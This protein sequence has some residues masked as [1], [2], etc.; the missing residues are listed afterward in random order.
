MNS[1]QIKTV[2]LFPIRNGYARKQFLIASLVMLAGM[3]IP[4]IPLFFL[5]GY[6]ARIVRQI[7][8]EKKEPSMTEWDN[9][10]DFFTD[11]ARLFA[12]H[13]V[14]TL[15]FLIVAFGMMFMFIFFPAILTSFNDQ[16]DRTLAPL[17]GISFVL[18]MLIFL[19]VMILL[20]PLQLIIGT[21]ETHVAVKG[22]F[23]AGLQFGEWW[24]ILRKGL[25]SFVMAFL[26]FFVVSFAL[27]L[28]IQISVFTIIL[29]CVLPFVIF[30]YGAYISLI[31]QALYAQAYQKTLAV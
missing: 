13:L 19:M 6:G 28:A 25:G 31:L 17:V 8:L 7:V 23:S 3:I 5:M 9:W 10:G 22:S 24:P 12:I 26:I 11:G 14:Y 27:N 29:I 18:G 2:L 15:P 1:E 21:A 30:P 4:I 16:M 20:L